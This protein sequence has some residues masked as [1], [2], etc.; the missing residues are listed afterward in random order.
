MTVYL[1]ARRLDDGEHAELELLEPPTHLGVY[2]TYPSPA[3]AAAAIT[4]SGRSVEDWAIYAVAEY[5]PGSGD[6]G[7]AT[8]Y[9][10]AGVTPA[11]EREAY[12]RGF[13]TVRDD[14]DRMIRKGYT[15]DSMLARRRDDIAQAVLDLANAR[16]MLAATEARQRAG[17]RS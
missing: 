3:A 5:P 17:E 7:R 1:P 12:Q 10:P 2:V 6:R 4:G 15:V 14:I 8:G 16:G 9:Q 13:E 11:D